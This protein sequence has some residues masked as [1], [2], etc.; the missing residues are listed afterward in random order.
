MSKIL[1]SVFISLISAHLSGQGIW[2]V[3]ELSD[4]PEPVTNNAVATDG[5]YVYSFMGIDSTKLYSGI[6]LKAFRYDI[7]SNIWDT[8]PSVP[9]NL[10]RIAASASAINGKIYIIGGYHVYS[11]LSEV[12]SNKVFIYDPDS[13]SYTSGANIT[14]A[15][16]DQI[17]SVWQ[18]SIIYVI[19][20]WSN[21]GN[22]NVV[23]IYD[24]ALDSWSMGTPLPAG[25]DYEAFG[26]SGVIIDNTIYYA[27]GVTDTW[28]FSMIPKL[29]TGVIDPLN[30]A[31]I[32]WSILDDS[33]GGLYR[34]GAGVFNDEPI[35][36]GGADKAYNFD[37]I[38]Y[39]SSLGVEPLNRVTTYHPLLSSFTESSGTIVPI[40][41]MRGIVK[42]DTNKFIIAGGMGP[43]QTVSDKTYLLE[44][45][46]PPGYE[47]I[48]L[49]KGDLKVY[50]NPVSGRMYLDIPD[51]EN[52]HAWVIVDLAGRV[53]SEGVYGEG[54]GISTTYLIG[55]MYYLQIT[56]KDRV[57]TTSFVVQHD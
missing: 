6:H 57:L 15:T 31:T 34:S 44:Y 18:D 19:S 45:V 10:S 9:D 51:Q 16:D 2:Q 1:L 4:M 52:D 53:L 40:M 49:H 37:G 14:I 41:D 25:L 20:G 32:S 21:S 50:P 13:N 35:W 43:G 30:P 22:I 26:A 12:S 29:R 33:L 48:I 3:T 7:A 54:Q 8:I 23:Q 36:F 38:D 39:A 11:N 24:P 56:M 27:G 28:V 46:I 42:I 55:G 47:E 17:Q 5:S